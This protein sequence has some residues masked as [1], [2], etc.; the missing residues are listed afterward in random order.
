MTVPAQS[1]QAPTD[2]GTL[3]TNPPAAA[4]APADGATPPA[5]AKPA[6][7]TTPPA[8]ADGTGKPAEEP[9]SKDGT[10]PAAPK[11]PEKY[12]LVVPKGAEEFVTPAHLDQLAQLAKQGDL[13]NE[14]AQ[15]A[16]ETWVD[17]AA[18]RR[19][20]LQQETRTH[21][22]YGG[23]HFAAN[24][25]LARS[26][27]A[28]FRPAGHPMTEGFTAFLNGEGGPGSHIQVFA[29]LADI[30]KAM[31]EDKPPAGAAK[32]AVRDRDHAAVLYG[33]S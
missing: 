12:S 33:G 18:A 7:D 9:A 29:L 15:A 26:V 22:T 10:P 32:G 24:E 20:A 28:R 4:A 16:L 13:T 21:P 23:D 5:D 6:G 3:L 25:Q 19:L 8:S 14:Q 17:V 11:A 31:A 27:I 1:G 30:G 2:A